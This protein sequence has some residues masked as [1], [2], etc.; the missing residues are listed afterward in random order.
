MCNLH[1]CYS[2]CT[3][4][5]LF[6]LVLHLNCTALSQS[7]SSNFF[8]CIINVIKQLVHASAVRMS[9]YW[10]FGK[11]G[12]HFWSSLNSPRAP[13][14]DIRTLAHELIVNSNIPLSLQ[15]HILDRMAR[16]VF[17]HKS[18]KYRLETAEKLKKEGELRPLVIAS[19]LNSFLSISF[20]CFPF[21]PKCFA[22]DSEVNP[23]P[24]LLL[25][26]TYL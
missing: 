9:R 12:E 16:L 23:I 3:G 10:A 8:V 4:V 13:Y 24:R 14:L 25:D 15:T 11:F 1:W 17:L 5:T 19:P 20:L 21:Q 22:R 6:A 26:S 18:V 7:E 2:F